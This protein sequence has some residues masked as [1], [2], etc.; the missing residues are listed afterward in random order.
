[1]RALSIRSFIRF[2]HRRNVVF[3]QPDGPISAVISL[4][5]IGRV[6][7]RTARKSP[8]H[9]DTSLTSKIVSRGTSARTTSSGT[10]TTTLVSPCS[11]T[12]T[13]SP[14]T[15]V[16]V[17]STSAPSPR[18]LV[19]VPQEDRR[20]VHDQDH[21]Q[22]H[23]DRGSGEGGPLLTRLPR[24]REDQRWQRRVWP[25]QRLQEA[26]VPARAEVSRY[27]PHQEEGRR[28]PEGP[29][30]GEDRPGEHARGCVREDVAPH[31]LPARGPDPV[32]RLADP[33]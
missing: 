12:G 30:Q 15:G 20:Q 23:H 10:R 6:T 16:R 7:S 13:G 11:L 22:E 14:A 21:R 5:A 24:P 17:T 25:L 19:S 33:L 3:P 26:C 8:Y 27:R 2:K 29:G 28:L 18:P 32:G 31:D 1:M 4:R 9:T